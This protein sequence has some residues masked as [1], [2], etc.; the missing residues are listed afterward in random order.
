MDRSVDALEHEVEETR[1]RLDRTLGGLQ[2]SLNIPNIA[3]ELRGTSADPKAIGAAFLCLR[4]EVGQNPAPAFL[5]CAG[6]SWLV[7]ATIRQSVA[8]RKPMIS[9]DIFPTPDV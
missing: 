3:Q 2:A 7:F 6:L 9:A 8:V 1:A 4:S 5:I